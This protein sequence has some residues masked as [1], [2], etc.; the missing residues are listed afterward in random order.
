MGS[1]LLWYKAVIHFVQSKW[2]KTCIMSSCMYNIISLI[3]E[4][5]ASRVS[6]WL[7]RLKSESFFLFPAAVPYPPTTRLTM[8]ELY[9]DGKPKVELLKSHLV[10]EGRLEED[11]ALRIINDGANILRHEKCMLE[12]EAPITGRVLHT[13]WLTVRWHYKPVV[14]HNQRLHPGC[15]SHRIFATPNAVRSQKNTMPT[16]FLIN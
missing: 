16:S 8:K 14:I 11:A 5:F 7:A 10:K 12:V 9:E 13:W 1:E 2:L 6:L 3:Y 15:G 4:M